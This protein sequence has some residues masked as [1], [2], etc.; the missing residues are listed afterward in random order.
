MYGYT[1]LSRDSLRLAL[2]PFLFL[3]VLFAS[4]TVRAE[5]QLT[6]GLYTTDKPTVLVKKFRPIIEALENSLSDRLGEPV[7]IRIKI[8]STYEKGVAALVNGDVDFSRFGPASY[9]SAAEQDPGLQ[10]LAVD[11]KDGSSTVT[12]IIAVRQ[13]SPIKSVEDLAGKRF[14]FGNKESTI[15]RYLAQA[16]LVEAGIRS[17]DLAEFAYL[18]RHDRVGRAVE[19]G[20]FDAGALKEGTFNKLKKKGLG[21]H[22]LVTFPNAN[23]PWVA[24][25]GLDQ[26]LVNMIRESMLA[27]EAPDAFKA[28]GRKRFVTAVDED[29]EAIRTSI[30]QN[31]R[32]FETSRSDKTPPVATAE[33]D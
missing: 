10:I 4:T 30:Q 31:D 23:K 17:E 33:S 18:D 3:A 27:L 25:S 20:T 21:L 1:F 11:S 8:S 14:A 22:A 24:R 29:F 15:G 13:G 12:G 28:L 9:V 2:V 26:D 6:F 16:V 19:Q 5:T 32:F 7:A